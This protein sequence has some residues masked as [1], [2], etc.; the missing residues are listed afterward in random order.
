MLYRYDPHNLANFHNYINNRDNLLLL[1]ELANGTLLAG[2]SAYPLD[3]Q[4]IERPGKGLLISLTD[5]K[6]YHAR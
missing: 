3:P 1:L 4:K 5:E 2:F 6:V